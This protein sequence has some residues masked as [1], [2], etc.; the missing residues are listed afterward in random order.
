VWWQ[1][2]SGRLSFNNITWSDWAQLPVRVLIL[3]SPWP[4]IAVLLA[5]GKSRGT[6]NSADAAPNGKLTILRSALGWGSLASIAAFCLLPATRSRYLMPALAPVLAWSVL[7][8]FHH[9]I[10]L[11]SAKIWQW[12][13]I[14]LMAVATVAA[15]ALPWILKMESPVP[16]ML[17]N[18]AGALCL[19]IVWLALQKQP[20]PLRF[21]LQSSI[22]LLL[23]MLIVTT[24]VLPVARLHEN[25]RPVADA[26]KALA[27]EP[28]S[29]VAINPGPQP[30]LFYL[31]QRCFE[32]VKIS[33]FPD[34]LAYILI[35]PR[36]WGRDEYRDRLMTRGFTQILTKVK[37]LRVENG[38]EFLM[39]GK[40]KVVTEQKAE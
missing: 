9:G 10:A 22:P 11:R 13:L 7:T 31:G 19:W 6:Q 33:E 24:T 36:E 21:F 38:R 4:I 3:F 25:V 12:I 20:T 16:A 28:G 35:P 14:G 17:W 29:I 40:E 32:G 8:I 26:V 15:A 30:F 5:F 34:D 1:Q 39:I 27:T 37:D 2:I 18:C 23:A